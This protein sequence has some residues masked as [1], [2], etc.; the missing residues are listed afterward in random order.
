MARRR[1]YNR[2]AEADIRFLMK[3]P[4]L[5]AVI[6]L[7]MLLCAIFYWI[8]QWQA[9]QQ[10]A[11][12]SAEP[13]AT[14][15]TVTTVKSTPVS[16]EELSV[17]M[18]DVGQG[19]ATLIRQGDAAMLID[20]GT[21][22]GGDKVVAYLK[23]QGI[24]RLDYVI[25]THAHSD[26]IGGMTRVLKAFKV[27]KFLMKFMPEGF[28][29]TTATYERMLNTLVD[30]N[31]PVKETA[32]GDVY[33]LGDATV[34]IV[35]PARDFEDM[36]DQSVVCLVTY[37][38]RRFLFQGDAETPSENAILDSGQDVAADV[39]KVGHHGSSTSTLKAYLQA[40]NPS[41][42]LISC[43]QDNEY[44]HPHQETLQK[45]KKQKAA[46]YR[47]DKNGTVVIATDGQTLTV[48][49]ER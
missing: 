14:R 40:V 34:R 21:A 32:V 43:G 9:E 2:S 18:I 15:A 17:H 11:V 47:T 20:A 44:G 35:G 1:N 22:E 30:K 29:P 49:K 7:I 19:D 10:A 38:Q 23:Q 42:A 46:V 3:H 4:W 36:N 8:P 13:T 6:L 26:H 45:L 31:V 5:I 41:V 16:G 12:V 48:K 28:T 25:A 24:E 37:G 39:L 27:N 33:K